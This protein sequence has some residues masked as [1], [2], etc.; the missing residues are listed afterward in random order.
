MK[1]FAVVGMA[2]AGK[3]EAARVFE[4]GGYTR[5]RFGDVTDEEI[6][7]RGLIVNEENER[8]VREALRNEYGM[9]AYAIL[10][11]PKIDRGF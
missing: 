1:V 6:N 5:I 4:A 2:G 9:A 3:S 7:N 10:N 8:M 11:R